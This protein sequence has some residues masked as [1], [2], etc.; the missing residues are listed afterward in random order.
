MVRSTFTIITR[1]TC[2]NPC[3]DSPGLK[4]T[5]SSYDTTETLTSVIYSRIEDLDLT[6]TLHEGEWIWLSFSCY[7]YTSGINSR[8]GVRFYVNGTVD[9][10]YILVDLIDSGTMYAIFL[11]CIVKD[12]LPGTY[13]ASVIAGRSG[14]D[15]TYASL[16]LI[17]QTIKN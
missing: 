4:Q 7:A 5:W 2:Q 9:Y 1:P 10:P 14:S 3:P 6:I 16:S 17:V 12:E 13:L 8:A 11:Q 15:C